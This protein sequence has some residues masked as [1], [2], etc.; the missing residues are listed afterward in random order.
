MVLGWETYTVLLG[1]M[2]LSCDEFMKFNEDEVVSAV[3]RV[4]AQGYVARP[5]FLAWHA[6]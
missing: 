6:Y 5:A 3:P 1:V 2:V 4:F